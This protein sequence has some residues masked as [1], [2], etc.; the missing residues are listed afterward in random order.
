M[1]SYYSCA[2]P[3]RLSGAY[4]TNI[5][6]PYCPTLNSEPKNTRGFSLSNLKP[7]HILYSILAVALIACLGMLLGLLVN[8]VKSFYNKKIKSQ[9]I[10]Y[11]NI[12]SDTSF[13]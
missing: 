11:I 9:P 6:L 8:A 2:A 3:M 1:F 13:A 4:I 7:K 12:N 5:T 10:R